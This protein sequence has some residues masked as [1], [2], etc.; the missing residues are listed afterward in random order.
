M[1]KSRKKGIEAK[2]K[3]TQ[4]LVNYKNLERNLLN[5]ISSEFNLKEDS[6]KKQ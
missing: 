3:K 5:E 2:E 6:K 4:K 1:D